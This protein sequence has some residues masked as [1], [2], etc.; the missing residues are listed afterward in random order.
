MPVPE[1]TV[2]ASPECASSAVSE[3]CDEA[4]AQ[5]QMLCSLGQWE[6]PHPGQRYS[7]TVLGNARPGAANCSHASNGVGKIGMAAKAYSPYPT[8]GW[9][10]G[11]RRFAPPRLRTSSIRP[12]KS[13]QDAAAARL[14]VHTANSTASSMATVVAQEPPVVGPKPDPMGTPRSSSEDSSIRLSMTDFSGF[15]ESGLTTITTSSTDA[16]SYMSIDTEKLPHISPDLAATDDDDPDPYGW[17]AQLEKCAV[18]SAVG[19]GVSADYLPVLQY[20]RAG[21]A[22]RTLLQRVLS[23]GPTPK[24]D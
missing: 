21:G 22:K 19:L 18:P 15:L 7:I 10:T 8:R 13:H 1:D 23:F 16:S 6:E 4:Q 17:D 3:K 2:T 9:A 12:L 20:R 5:K 24:E 11:A 14:S